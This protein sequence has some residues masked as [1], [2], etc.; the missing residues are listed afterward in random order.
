MAEKVIIDIELKGFGAAQKSLDDLTKAQIEQQDAIKATKDEIKAYEKELALFAKARE[1]GADLT[2]EQIK[3]EKELN[4]SIKN[5]KIQLAGQKDELSKTNA[6]RR[7]AVKEVDTYNKALQGEIGSN[8]QLRAQLKI[9]TTEYDKMSKEQRE[10]TEEGKDMTAQIK[11]LTDKLKEN[12]S[13]VGDNRR[14][15]GNYSESIREAF[16]N[17]EIFGVSLNGLRDSYQATKDTTTGLIKNLVLTESVQKSQAAAT[18]AQT[19]AQKGLNVA[20][21]AGKVAMNIFKLALIATGIG[22]FVVIIGSLVAYFTQTQKGAEVVRKVM[23]GLGATIDVLTD[24]LS[25]FGGGIAKIFSG[26]FAG[27]LNDMKES[28]QGIGDEIEREI[29]LVTE[30]ENALIS[31][32]K[33]EI[34]VSVGR[35]EINKKIK[36]QNRLAEDTTKSLNTRIEA[37]E[38]VVA[39]E[40]EQ[41]KIENDLAN[42]R[43]ANSLQ[44]IGTQEQQ[45]AQL[46]TITEAFQQSQQ[47]VEVFNQ[48]LLAIGISETAVEDVKEIADAIISN[49]NAIAASEE[50]LTTAGNKLNTLN[51][52]RSNERKKASEDRK[53]E[54]EEREKE[55]DKKIEKENERLAKLDEILRSEKEN[56]DFEKKKLLEELNISEEGKVLTQTEADAKKAIIDQY[57]LDVAELEQ[58]AIKESQELALAAIEDR[59]K[60]EEDAAALLTLQKE[61]Q[62]L[63]DFNAANG[64]EEEQQRLTKE[65]NLA[66]LEEAKTLAQQLEQILL[67]STTDLEASADG[68]IAD[69]LLSDEQLKELKK[70]LAELGVDLGTLDSQINEVGRDEE[71]NTLGDSLGLD[72]EK[73]EK[74]I[75]SFQFAIGAID[76]IL[77][78]ASQN[79][80]TKTD[81]RIAAIDKQVESGVI[82]EEAAEKQ[83]T[84]V[85]KE[86][87]KQQKKMDIAS[88]TMSYFDGLIQAFAQALRLGPVAGPI[89]GAINAGILTGTYSANIKQIKA[90]KFAEGGVIQGNSHAQGGVPFTVAGRGGFEAEGGE[91]IHKTKAV[92]HYGLPFM[93]ALNNLQLPKMFAEGG[94]VAPV[95]ASSISQQ[96]SD[97]VSELVSV[98]ENRS[99][100]VVNVEQD[101]SNLQ[102]KVNN[103]ESARTY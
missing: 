5:S 89:V 50:V 28:F 51:Q 94:Y 59:I 8:E 96:V 37:A 18:N 60:N 10:S 67:Q 71:G 6:Q 98:N 48:K 43:L 81:E 99:M 23:A 92:E 1:L 97:G 70:R 77:A 29:V 27:G 88:A 7:T 76:Q 31:L 93:N 13:A 64:N 63:K 54:A 85:R 2:D 84:K 103:V 41:I 11:G 68:G 102:N 62:F 57:N 49:N 3:K 56:L 91:F 34:A 20:T 21:I 25:A 16:G 95:T 86:A 32:E 75:G 74:I 9:L 35:S 42:E 17:T 45:K 47:D 78:I 30:L 90:Q 58:N 15:V 73:T 87:F 83:K 53:K 19:T 33:R 39:L 46:K 80:K 55:N 82:S 69:A 100:Q 24:R 65:R 22:A 12:E 4:D 44:L 72:D 61:K 66:R 101:F 38:K 26:D 36:E 79:L 52:Q 40:Q 14:N